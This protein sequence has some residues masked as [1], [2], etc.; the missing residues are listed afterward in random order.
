M[1]TVFAFIKSALK[2]IYFIGFIRDNKKPSSIHQFKVKTIE[3]FEFDLAKLKGKKILIVNTASQCGFT[4]Q[5]KDLQELY[6]KY[7]DHNFTILGFPCNQFNNQDPGTNAEIKDFCTKN[8]SVT[9]PMMEK[10]DV[11]GPNA[12]LLYQ[13]LTQKEKNGVLNSVVIW[14]FQKYMIDENGFLVDYISFLRK[15]NSR[16]ITNWIEKK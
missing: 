13:W 12:S 7:K 5:F 2:S 8:Y 1:K 15:P 11:K 4:P 14:N 3:G 16:K 9:F 6:I 10:T